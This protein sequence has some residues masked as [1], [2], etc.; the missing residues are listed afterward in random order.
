MEKQEVS[1]N[2]SLKTLYPF[3]DQEGLLRVG[4][5]L[6]QCT[7]PYQAMHQTILPPHHHFTK[8]V[9]SAEH[10]RLHH[11]GPQLPTASLC[12]KYSIPRIRNLVKSVI[13]QCKSCYKFK[14]QATQQLMGE[15]PPPRV[16][17]SRP[18]LTTGVDYTGPISLRL[19]TTHS[20]TITKGY[21]A[22]FV[23]FVTRA[24]HIEVTSMTTEAFLAALWCFIARRGKPRTMYLDNGTTFQGASNKRHEIYNMLHSSSQMA[25]VQDFLTSKGCDWKFIP[26][27]G[28][29]FGGLGSSS[30]IHDVPPEENIG[31]LHCYLTK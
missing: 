24:V 16:Q 17:L 12:E 1:S 31:F 22:I 30:N 3:I 15:L 11:A 26:L 29:R 19:W 13:H 2:S 23:C 4:R 9:V 21:I 18:F 8:L 10:I 27:H 20:K 25:S 14:A 7:L 6:Q 28:P 5:Q